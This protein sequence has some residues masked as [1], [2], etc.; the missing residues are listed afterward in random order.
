MNIK[1]QNQLLISTF[2]LGAIFSCKPATEPEKEEVVK[3]NIVLIMADDMGYNE[4]GVYGQKMIQTPHIDQLAKEGMR[5]TN[6]YAGNTVCGPS[7]CSMM[8]GRHPGNASVRGN[9]GMQGDNPVRLNKTGIRA[10]DKTIGEVLQ[11]RGYKT[12]L[13]GKWHM[14]S[15]NDSLNTWPD[16]RGFDYSI[17]ERWGSTI[18]KRRVAYQDSTGFYFDHNY[19][20]ELWENGEMVVIEENVDNKRGKMMDDIST[21]KGLEFIKDNKDS[22]FFIFF[23]MKIPHIPETFYEDTKSYLEKGW[24]ECERV[25]SARISYLDQLVKKITDEL[26]AQGLRDNTMVIFTS[27]NG[28]HNEGQIFWPRAM[29]P[30]KHDKDFF[31]SNYPLRGSKRDLYD[32]GIRVPFIVNWPGKVSPNT[33][34]EH[35]GAFWDLMATFAD[36]SGEPLDDSYVHDGISMLPTILGT[37]TQRT[38]PYLYWEFTYQ[39]KL[40]DPASYGFYQAI[41]MDSMKAVRYGIH[42]PIELYHIEKDPGESNN[43]SGSYPAVINIMDSLL[44]AARSENSHYPF[45]G[46]ANYDEDTEFLLESY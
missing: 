16:A 1:F 22:P 9:I 27:D 17:R 15:L 5:F 33:I 23:S 42:N 24:P 38:H 3:P 29:D 14:E 21:E 45:G 6:F 7:R 12:A 8:T 20:S 44:V 19:P 26:E 13:C 10:E 36:V 35:I 40:K 2:L 28:G 39:A 37:G 41:R 4:L 30:C 32:G 25:H 31:Q 43:L 34:N 18:D 46:G 11:E